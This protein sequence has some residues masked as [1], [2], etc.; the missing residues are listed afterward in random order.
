VAEG[1][2]VRALVASGFASFLGQGVALKVASVLARILLARWLGPAEF[3]LVAVCDTVLAAA[4]LVQR[5]GLRE[6]VATADDRSRLAST[7]FWLS[8][9]TGLLGGALILLAQPFVTGFFDDPRLRGLLVFLGLTSPLVTLT[10]APQGLVEGEL[11]FAALARVNLLTGLS[12][13]VLALLLARFGWGPFALVAPGPV[14]GVLGLSGLLFVLRPW[15]PGRPS[16]RLA[17]ALMG[18]GLPLTAAGLAAFTTTF[19]DNVL[20]G[21]FLGTDSL[22]LYAFAFALANQAY[23]LVTTGLPSLLPAAFRAMGDRS[24]EE[25]ISAFDQALAAMALLAVPLCALQAI[26]ARP[27]MRLLFDAR[28]APAIP[29]VEIVSLAMLFRL[30]ATPARHL[31]EARRQFAGLALGGALSAAVFL[32]LVARAAAA[33][34][35]VSV[36]WAVTLGYAADAALKLV[37]AKT[38]RRCL[39]RCVL[40]PLALGILSFG[41][42]ALLRLL[43]CEAASAAAGLAGALAFGLLVRRLR[44]LPAVAA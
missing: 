11:R 42:S 32:S 43:E 21:R 1:P 23:L 6:Q 19:G 4:V 27:L 8:L 16:V 9:G 2:S 17:K 20:V 3:G 41:P 44:L 18:G 24:R 26:L 14:V 28:W 34:N 22:G 15:W 37:Q 30:V 7:A 31:L 13:T 29:V 10:T 35:L 25:Q 40:S 36:G 5:A 39:L 33:G 12:A 38:S